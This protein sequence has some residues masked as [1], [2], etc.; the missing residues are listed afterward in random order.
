MNSN[1]LSKFVDWCVVNSISDFKAVK[2]QQ[3]KLKLE[4]RLKIIQYYSDSK[5]FQ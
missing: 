1:R 3:I 5:S 4:T 2:R